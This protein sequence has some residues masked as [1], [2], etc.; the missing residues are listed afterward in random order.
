MIWGLIHRNGAPK[1]CNH[2]T[3]QEGAVMHMDAASGIDKSYVL[4]LLKELVATN[5]VNPTVGRGP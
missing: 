5:S 4:D 1:P 3:T 2:W